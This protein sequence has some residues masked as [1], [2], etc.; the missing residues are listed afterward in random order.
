MVSTESAALV[1]KA[2][3]H[4]TLLSITYHHNNNGKQLDQDTQQQS[5]IDTLEDTFDESPT[6]ETTTV[7]LKPEEGFGYTLL[8]TLIGHLVLLIDIEPDFVDLKPLLFIND[9]TIKEK[10]S[11]AIWLDI[12][13]FVD[14]LE[15]KCQRRYKTRISMLQVDDDND[16]NESNESNDDNH[17]GEDDIND[18]TTNDY[19]NDNE[20]I[21]SGISLN[22]TT[23]MAAGKMSLSD[24]TSMEL[25]DMEY[26]LDIIT[27]FVQEIVEHYHHHQQQQQQQILD[28]FVE[29]QLL[30]SWIHFIMVF[31]IAMLS[32]TNRSVRSK[33]VN[34]ILPTILQ[35][36]KIAYKNDLP[37]KSTCQMLWQRTLQIYGL[38]ATNLMRTETYGLIAKYFDTYFGLDSSFD[39]TPIVYL[40][41]RYKKEFFAMLQSGLQSDDALA[42]KYTSFILKRVI[43]YCNKYPHTIKENTQQPWTNYFQWNT[44]MA[45][46]YTNLWDDWFL[47]YEIMHENVIHLVQPVLPRFEYLLSYEPRL[48]ASW[49]TLILHRGFNNETVVI[50]KEIW[51]YI[52]ARQNLDTLNQLGCQLNFFFGTLLKTID[53]TTLYSVPT[54]GTLVSPFGEHLKSFITKIVSAFNNQDTKKQFLQQMI[55]RLAHVINSHIMILYIMEGLA[56]CEPFLCWTKEELKSLRYLVDRHRHFNTPNR[57][58]FIR[59]LSITCFQLFADPPQLSFSDIAKTVSSMFTDYPITTTSYEYKSIKSW[60]KENVAKEKDLGDIVSNLKSRINTYIRD[61]LDE[62][63]PVGILINQSNVLARSTL[64]LISDDNGNINSETLQALYSDCFKKLQDHTASLWSFNRIII[65]FVSLWQIIEPCFGSNLNIN[66][67]MNEGDISTYQNILK[68]IEDQLMNNE[69]SIVIDESLMELLILVL[70]RI[71]SNTTSF[72]LISKSEKLRDYHSCIVKSLFSNNKE[73]NANKEL[74]KFTHLCLLRLVYQLANEWDIDDLE[75]TAS[76]MKNIIDL[77]MNRLPELVKQRQWGDTIA[78]FIR[79]KWDCLESLVYFIKKKMTSESITEIFDPQQLYQIAVDQL[80]C[81]SDIC[82][83]AI[84]N[85][86]T[87]L[88]SLSW[89]KQADLVMA[90]VN[91]TISVLK[92]YINSSK[93]F[94]ILIQALMRMVFQP[95]LLSEPTLNQDNGPLKKAVYTVLEIGDWKPFIVCDVVEILHSFW[96]TYTPDAINSMILYTKEITTFLTFGPAR[97][98]EDQKID[99]ATMTKLQHPDVLAQAK[100]TSEMT[101]NQN[102]YYARVLMND[103]VLRLDGTNPK[104]IEFAYGL[105]KELIETN[106]K[107]ELYIGVFTNTPTHRFKIRSWCTITLLSRFIKDEH[108]KEYLERIFQLMQKETNVSVRS[109]MEWTVV[110]LLLQHPEYITMLY[111]QLE[112]SGAKPSYI[113]SVMTV[114]F[115]LGDKIDDKMAES[116]FEKIFPLLTPWLIPNHFN[117]RLYAYC[118]WDRNWN[119]CKRRGFNTKL[120]ENPYLQAINNYMIQSP[121]CKKMFDKIR[122]HYYMTTFDPVDDYNL[123]FIFRENLHIFDVAEDE[124]IGSRAFMRANSTVVTNCPFI[125]SNKQYKY[126]ACDPT[127]EINTDKQ[128]KKCIDVTADDSYQKKITPWEMMLQTDIDL[129]KTLV[130]DKRRRND[131]IVVASLVDR[132]A[133]LAGLCRTCEIFNASQLVVN[134]ISVKDDPSFATISVSSEKW[135]PLVEVQIQ[136]V[137]DFLKKKKEEG[138]V[139]CGLEQTTNSVKLGEYDFPE[140]CILLLGKEREGIPPDLLQLLDQTIEIPQYGLIRS[141]NVHVSGAICM[142][143]YTK[144]M[145]WRQQ[146]IL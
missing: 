88:L 139:I 115:C 11:H 53:S 86:I 145:K 18:N 46:K 24:F 47:L 4:Y 35:W 80:E 70:R 95:N 87:A 104:H 55:H 68:R 111:E 79:Y 109:Y 120:E 33:F 125:N 133:N 126:A 119:A 122:T 1:A 140:K 51:E 128:D 85:C 29:D 113:I 146:A 45:E 101:F 52:F 84:I 13:K 16:D 100:G 91:Y 71:L 23:T 58:T 5:K 143:E 37:F 21:V 15:Q 76:D 82:A 57:K 14:K 31:S 59:K 114:T 72:D 27:Q 136:E 141:L 26:S 62:D 98:R 48:D 66:I 17:P 40:D 127:E 130:K 105:M 108:V 135:M 75:V 129:T 19:D 25:L 81:A 112:K 30:N 92:E 60:L 67:L 22:T 69:S 89:T 110:R 12:K 137:P 54:Q 134:N 107:P 65:L 9:N 34:D 99:V 63:I 90:S 121:D 77:S 36:Q 6:A 38:P 116:Y 74:S 41:L 94:P 106:D 2:A 93:V 42:R 8:K 123:E 20:S 39:E 83:E 49:W 64:F 124:R 102:D 43:D 117:I 32:C 3:A 61:D 7:S 56:D 28:I 144:Q 142:Y 44:D 73:K 50:Q 78:N 10:N 96:S 132:I 131:L 118:A 103:L 97:D 138:Y